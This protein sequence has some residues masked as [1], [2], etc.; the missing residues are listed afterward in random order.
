[1]PTGHNKNH[2]LECPWFGEPTDDS[3][4]SAFTEDAQSP[5]RL[6]HGDSF[7]EDKWTEFIEDVV[8]RMVLRLTQKVLDE[9]C[10]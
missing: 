1:M 5:N 8:L 10:V 4:T 2:K 3:K 6:P 9:G 7:I